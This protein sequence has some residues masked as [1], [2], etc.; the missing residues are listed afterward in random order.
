MEK[1]G[2]ILR[3]EREKRGLTI[4]ALAQQTRINA[5]YFHAIEEGDRKSLPGGFFY[6]SFLRQYARLLELPDSVYQDEITRSLE[7]ETQEIPSL[8]E[9]HID[10]PPMPT[11]TTDRAA[12]TRRWV[13][14]LA[15]L[16]AV[17]ALATMLYTVYL[18]WRTPAEVAEN[19]AAEPP[20]IAMPAPAEPVPAPAVEAT[21]IP[22]PGTP[23]EPSGAT[24]PTS[25]VTTPEADAPV[26]SAPVR[27]RLAAT[28]AVWVEVWADGRRVFNNLMNASEARSFGAQTKIRVLLGNAGGMNLEWNGRAVEPVAPR[29]QVRTVEFGP[30][31]FQVVAPAPPAP[32]AETTPVP[33]A[34]A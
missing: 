20:P 13:I 4:D 30:E 32:P 1:L 3:R 15:G 34:S 25:P 14:R 16:V 31:G 11:G 8:P 33:P 10:V 19:K 12:E 21:P 5:L 23:P 29:G 24:P 2:Q 27:L 28:E 22:P 17:V 26:D 18:R 7:Q 6:R 9:R